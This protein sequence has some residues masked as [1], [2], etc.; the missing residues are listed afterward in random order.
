MSRI[1]I[2]VTYLLTL[3]IFGVGGTVVYLF[4][5]NRPSR[6]TLHDLAAGTIV[7]KR[8]DSRSAHPGLWRGHVVILCVL[9]TILVASVIASAV[10]IDQPLISDLLH[11]LEAVESSS[12]IQSAGVFSGRRWG[13]QGSGTYFKVFGLLRSSPESLEEYSDSIA[14]LIFKEYPEIVEAD[15]L[16]I[17]LAYGYDIGI[18]RSYRHFNTVLTPE[19]WIERLAI[20]DR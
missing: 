14:S 17:A 8:V 15:Q 16:W 13:P 19:E 5:F 18:S 4:L 7:V 9:M 20:E 10:I 2:Q 11:V 6:R 3:I 12:D 1:P